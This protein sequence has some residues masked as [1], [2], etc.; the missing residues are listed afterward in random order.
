VIIIGLSIFSAD[1]QQFIQAAVTAITSNLQPQFS[2][3]NQI[4]AF[5]LSVSTVLIGAIVAFFLLRFDCTDITWPQMLN[6]QYLFESG[7]NFFL[8]AGKFITAYTQGCSFSTQLKIVL[9]TI[10]LIALLTSS[11]KMDNFN[12]LDSL[13]QTTSTDWLVIGL[14]LFSSLSL[15]LYSNFLVGLISLS[16][17]GLT[18]A[19]FFTIHGAIDLS[20]T[21]LL[22]DVLAVVIILTCFTGLKHHQIKD[23]SIQKWIN[24][25]ISISFGAFITLAL[26]ILRQ[27]TL[28]EE[29]Q[30]YFINNSY[31]LGHGKNIVNVILVDFRALDTLGEGLVIVAT[32]VG[33][34]YLMK[35]MQQ[36]LGKKHVDHS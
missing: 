29:L 4:S 1:L 9:A 36:S 30:Q 24:F 15:I 16:L 8:K 31:T 13:S 7:L 33:I 27:K 34:A 28:N 19:F 21:Q 12:I 14:L 32:A 20:I 23:T 22:T 25:L 11:I 5:T 6:P 2:S 35:K 17:M 10:S 18:V 26:L 3:P